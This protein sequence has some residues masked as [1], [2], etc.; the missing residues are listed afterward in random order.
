MNIKV[1]IKQQQR[2]GSIPEDTR[3]VWH[4]LRERNSLVVV[5]EDLKTLGL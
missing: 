3:H 1:L 2:T 5:D 4:H